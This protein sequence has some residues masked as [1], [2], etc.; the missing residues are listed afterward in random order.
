VKVNSIPA[1]DDGGD[2]EDGIV[3]ANDG[4]RVE[5]ALDLAKDALTQLAG[6]APPCVLELAT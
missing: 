1:C 3:R 4:I 6:R 2:R 5:P